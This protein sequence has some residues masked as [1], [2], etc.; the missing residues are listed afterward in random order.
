MKLTPGRLIGAVALV[1]AIP[2]IAAVA[3]TLSFSASDRICAGVSISEVSVAGLT[4]AQAG[5]I[6]RKWAIKR[7]GRRIT[8]TALDARWVG[9]VEDF[10]ARVKWK[11]SVD[12]A[13]D[14]GRK[15][16]MLNRIVCVCT[17]KGS[18]KRI[19]AEVAL[20]NSQIQKTIAK[21]A[22][23]INRPHK[24]AKIKVVAGRL[25]VEQD[26]VGLVL[27]EKRAI[28]SISRALE[29]DEMVAALPVVADKPDVTAQDARGIDTLLARFTTPFNPGKR[30]RTH[31]LVLAARGINGT[32]VK[33]GQKFS[34]NN[35]VGPR[36][37][38]R[39][40]RNAPIF[41]RGK[42]EPGI[43]GGICQ[44][45]TTLYNA[46]LLAGIRVLE[47][48]PHSRTV[49]YVGPGRD[50][51]VAYGLR[52]FR[53]ENSNTSSI[54]ILTN[55]SRG[56][57]TV[58]IYGIADDKKNIKIFAG[59]AK[60]TPAKA[61]Q[62]V[63]DPALSSGAH[64]VVDKGSRGVSITV[65]RKIVGPDGTEVTEVVSKDRY[66]AQP[67]IVAVGPV[68]IEAE[69]AEIRPEAALNTLPAGRPAASKPVASSL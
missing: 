61:M 10:G 5:E 6:V 24:D 28:E 30:D 39:G 32:I 55:I 2:I 19:R 29:S 57:L 62:T 22:G 25:E 47:R 48:Y 11:E 52:D 66:P 8:L 56:N 14:V 13:F 26:S 36:V 50:A 33:P 37:L 63:N 17:P 42:L 49:P 44:V 15:G 58:D 16:G 20:N 12:R 64:Q 60:Y 69:A 59:A 45:S 67:K 3:K 34:Y 53:F 54:C 40:F 18:G 23:T 31:N 65:Y 27:D 1:V 43:G 41:V 51:T 38:N 68:K 7:S 21:V 46:I 4:K 35:A 9:A